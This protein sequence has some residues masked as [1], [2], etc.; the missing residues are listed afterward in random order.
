MIWS[1]VAVWGVGMLTDRLTVQFQSAAFS[2]NI[3]EERML[4]KN[5]VRAALKK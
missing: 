3:F 1:C 5:D 4:I 2:C